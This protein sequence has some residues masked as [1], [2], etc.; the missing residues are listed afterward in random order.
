MTRKVSK[1]WPTMVDPM[2]RVQSQRPRVRTL[3]LA[4]V[5]ELANSPDPIGDEAG[6]HEARHHPKDRL[7]RLLVMPAGVCG[8]GDGHGAGCAE[9]RGGEE[10]DPDSAPRGLIA[11]DLGEHVTKDIGNREQQFG[12]AD[13]ERPKPADFLGDQVRYQQD[14]DEDEDEGIEVF[15]AGHGVLPLGYNGR[16]KFESEPGL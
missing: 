1:A 15:V 13:G 9:Q 10:P 11:I 3:S 6:G 5:K 7:K 14:N 4:R 8:E 12:A 16:R 2:V